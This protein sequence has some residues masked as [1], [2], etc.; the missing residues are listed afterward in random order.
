MSNTEKFQIACALAITGAYIYSLF[1]PKKKL[2]RWER[3][4]AVFK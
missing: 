4:L 2:S 1:I 3:F